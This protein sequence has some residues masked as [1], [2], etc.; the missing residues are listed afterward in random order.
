MSL[1]ILC[2][3]YGNIYDAEKVVRHCM[4]LMNF[5]RATILHPSPVE[6]P[7]IEVVQANMKNQNECLV[8]EVPDCVVCDHIL[9]VHWDGY[10]INP[11]LWSEDFLKYDWI[12]AP[13]PLK[14][15]PNPNWRVGSGGFFLCSKEIAAWWQSICNQEEP[16]DWQIGALYRDKFENLGMKFASL[17]VASKFAKECDLEDINIP[18]GSTFGF[19][20]FQYN[21]ELREEYRKRVYV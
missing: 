19:H 16:F 5:D 8:R 21:P 17:D 9:S 12:G 14:N 18:E 11:Q 3:N 13:W 15:L 6:L 7:G 1:Q 2:T 20:G 4:K 10:I